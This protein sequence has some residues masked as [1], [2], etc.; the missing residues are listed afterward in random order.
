MTSKSCTTSIGYTKTCLTVTG[1]PPRPR[2]YNFAFNEHQILDTVFCYVDARDDFSPTEVAAI[3]VPVFSSRQQAEGALRASGAK[4]TSS[5]PPFDWVR[6]HGP[7]YDVH[8]EFKH[9]RLSLVTLMRA[10]EV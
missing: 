6:S 10:V 9:G 2:G 8:F 3:G 4:F 1:P 7:E 5:S